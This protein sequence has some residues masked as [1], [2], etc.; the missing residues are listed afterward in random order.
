MN[1][2]SLITKI[3]SEYALN[4]YNFFFLSYPQLP[5]LFHLLCNPDYMQNI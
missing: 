2:V 5:E 4:E 3:L 1:N